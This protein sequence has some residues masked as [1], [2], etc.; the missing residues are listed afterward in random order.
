MWSEIL[1]RRKHFW[2]SG[3]K[4]EDNNN[5]DPKETKYEEVN[6]SSGSGEEPMTVSC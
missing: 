5:V 2:R 6:F 1:K 3:N 4:W